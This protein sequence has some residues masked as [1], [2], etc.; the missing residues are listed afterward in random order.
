M[1]GSDFPLLRQKPYLG[2]L[3]DSSDDAHRDRLAVLTHSYWTRRFAADPGVLGRPVTIDGVDHVVVGVLEKTAGPLE[4]NVALF[5]AERWPTPARRGPFF[6]TAIA[7][8]KPGVA[9]SVAGQALRSTNARLFPIWRSSYQNEQATWSMM[10]LKERAVGDV[11]TRLIFM[12]SAVGLV[13]LIA[14]A[15][16]V[17][18]LIARGLHRSR[19][20]AIRGALGASRRRILQYVFV[21]AGILSTAAA[22]VGLG[23]A[24]GLLQLIA[25]Y[26]A[27]YI[28]RIDEIRVFGPALLWL[29]GLTLASAVMIG[30]VPALHGSRIRADAALRAGGRAATTARRRDACSACSSPPS[31]ARD[32]AACRGGAGAPQPR[33]LESGAGRPRYGPDSHRSGVADRSPRRT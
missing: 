13:L 12:L 17:N 11:G 2:R 15:N 7:R 29:A 6:T 10:D 26:G 21:E 28:P 3:F 8:L 24:I 30:L 5:T 18:L 31:S 23:V 33:L 16:A 9:A 27:D 14:C 20:L 19:E 22:L 1:T 4:R 32:A 25:F